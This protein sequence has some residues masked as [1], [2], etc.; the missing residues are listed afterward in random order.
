LAAGRRGPSQGILIVLFGAA[1]N[2][3]R[4]YD[5]GDELGATE[6]TRHVHSGASIL[7]L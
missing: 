4:T 2:R 7:S 1:R 3:K 6:D 5:N